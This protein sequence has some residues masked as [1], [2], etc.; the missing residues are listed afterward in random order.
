MTFFCRFI[1]V[2][3]RLY[4]FHFEYR[5]GAFQCKIIFV[6]RLELYNIFSLSLLIMFVLLLVLEFLLVLFSCLY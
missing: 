2:A 4:D 1:D 5:V 6:D 3:F